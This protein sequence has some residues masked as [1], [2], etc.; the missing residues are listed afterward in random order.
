MAG[1]NERIGEGLIRIGAMNKD[2]VDIILKRQK[3][4]DDRLFGEIAVELGFVNIEAII[5]YLESKSKD[6]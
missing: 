6:V 3:G 5:E 4:G 2:Q 1:V